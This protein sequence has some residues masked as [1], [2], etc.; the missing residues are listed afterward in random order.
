MPDLSHGCVYLDGFVYARVCE[1]TD[2]TEQQQQ[3]LYLLSVGTLLLGKL[4]PLT[5][6]PFSQ[7]ACC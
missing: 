7:D 4:K 3:I 5:N 1:E 2:Y 6:E